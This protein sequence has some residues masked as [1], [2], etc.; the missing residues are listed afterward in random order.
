MVELQQYLRGTCCLLLQGGRVGRF[1]SASSKFIACFTLMI[2]R[3]Q[4]A[5][6]RHEKTVRLFVTNCITY[7]HLTR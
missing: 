3:Y 5:Q 7:V 1:L 4:Y 6:N 2:S